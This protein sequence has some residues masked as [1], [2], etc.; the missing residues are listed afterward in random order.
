MSRHNVS[1]FISCERLDIVWTK[2][3][4]MLRA[5]HQLLTVFNSLSFTIKALMLKLIHEESQV[6]Y[7]IPC[8]SQSHKQA[9]SNFKSKLSTNQDLT[10]FSDQIQKIFNLLCV[11]CCKRVT[12]ATPYPAH[13]CPSCARSP[14]RYPGQLYQNLASC[15][16]STGTIVSRNCFSQQHTMFLL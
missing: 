10:T 8:A 4:K 7:S 12:N 13:V 5:N 9:S 3:M 1:N 2:R 15:S 11:F 16:H 14:A 6:Y